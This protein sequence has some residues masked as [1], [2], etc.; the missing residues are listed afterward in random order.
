MPFDRP[1]YSLTRPGFFLQRYMGI[2]LSLLFPSRFMYTE[3]PASSS[4]STTTSNND[5]E[6]D[7]DLVSLA[8][9]LPDTAAALE[10]DTA[11]LLSQNNAD[12]GLEP[13]LA[14]SRPYTPHALGLGLSS[15]R[16]ALSPAQSLI[17][18]PA[19]AESSSHAM[20]HPSHEPQQTGASVSEPPRQRHDR[21]LDELDEVP[22][23]SPSLASAEACAVNSTLT[24][25]QIGNAGPPPP[26]AGG[27]GQVL[28]V[29]IPPAQHHPGNPFV[30]SGPALSPPP[31]TSSATSSSP[32]QPESGLQAPVQGSHIALDLVQEMPF[33][34]SSPTEPAL[35]LDFAEFDFEGLSTLEKIYLFSR[36]RAGFQRVFIAHAL[37][38]FLRSSF[39]HQDEAAH[40]AVSGDPDEPAAEITPAEAVEYVLPLLNGLAM[41]DGE[42]LHIL[43]DLR[44]SFLI[45]FSGCHSRHL[46]HSSH[47]KI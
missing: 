9:P 22:P 39:R 10:H 29:T 24:P 3:Q 42:Y 26:T 34:M 11:A 18:E 33:G 8:S 27:S 1:G 38:G 47:I 20:R 28:R 12:L 31:L 44:Q 46:H 23:P 6:P 45:M 25:P 35:N 5:T 7:P 17:R 2:L 36:S 21:Q 43:D 37:P 15:V 32:H 4:A 40:G 16:P 14:D 30:H 19:V 13:S 41:D